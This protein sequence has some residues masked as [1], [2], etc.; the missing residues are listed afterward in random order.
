MPAGKHLGLRLRQ[1]PANSGIR[2]PSDPGIAGYMRN[3]QRRKRQLGEWVSSA[4]ETNSQGEYGFTNVR[5]GCTRLRRLRPA[6][7]LDGKDTIGTAGG[8]VGTDRFS[9][10]NLPATTNATGYNFAELR[11]ASLTG[12]V[13]DDTAIGQGIMEAR[14]GGD[15]RLERHVDRH[16]RPRGQAWT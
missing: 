4:C 15:R 13:W 7:Y 10:I 1:Q 2:R 8:K 6:G 14:R 9:G 16:R 3:P 12:C 5:P 11:P